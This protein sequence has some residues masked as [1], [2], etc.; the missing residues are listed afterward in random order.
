MPF[1]HDIDP[2]GGMAHARFRGSVAEDDLRCCLSRVWADPRWRPGY[3]T[4]LDFSE[5]TALH[6]SRGFLRNFAS[7]VSTH[8]EEPSPTRTAI[9]ASRPFLL[10][11][12]P[13]LDDLNVGFPPGFR[14]FPH[15]GAA[16]EWVR[17]GGRDAQ[18]ESAESMEI[19]RGCA[20]RFHPRH[21][22]L[23]LRFSG[24]LR[25]SELRGLQQEVVSDSRW[26]NER[27]LLADLEGVSSADLNAQD[28]IRVAREAEWGERPPEPGRLALVAPG[29][30]SFALLQRFRQ[31]LLA[32][33]REVKVLR[34][35]EDALEW[36]G[37]PQDLGG[38]LKEEQAGRRPWPRV[39]SPV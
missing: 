6:L 27:Q 35:T 23:H 24:V 9:V 37:L 8:G 25:G 39:G 19:P 16:T 7:V 21:P 20:V 5:A 10:E 3:A 18:G 13:S 15:R 34:R 22:L 4:L 36:L 32:S 29:E 28:L 12:L 38:W 31:I 17:G 2:V 1:L 11:Q 33:P 26:S 14:I 30:F